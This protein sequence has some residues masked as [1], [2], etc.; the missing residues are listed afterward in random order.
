MAEKADDRNPLL[1]GESTSVNNGGSDTVVSPEPDP[2]P[3]LERLTHGHIKTLCIFICTYWQWEIIQK[4]RSSKDNQEK[5]NQK[6]ELFFSIIKLFFISLIPLILI[7]MGVFAQIFTCFSRQNPYAHWKEDQS[8]LNENNSNISY[9][10]MKCDTGDKNFVSGFIIPDAIIL[11]LS[12]WVY[13]VEPVY[14]LIYKTSLDTL[15]DE[16]KRKICNAEMTRY[17]IYSTFYIL[18][19]CALTIV[20]IFCFGFGR[21]D[22]IIQSALSSNLISSDNSFKISAIICSLS[23]FVALDLLYIHVIMRYTYRCDLL[24]GYL[25]S[26]VK[27]EFPKDQ[28]NTRDTK[29]STAAA[30]SATSKPPASQDQLNTG[31]TNENTVEFT[32]EQRKKIEVASKFLKELNDNSIATGI[33]IVIAGFTA[34]SCIVNLANNTNCPLINKHWQAVVVALRLV[35]WLYIV[36]FPLYRAAEVNETSHEVSV[37]L[38]VHSRDPQMVSKGVKYITSKARLIGMSVQPWLP[39]ALLLT[40]IFAVML[41]SG[42]KYFHLL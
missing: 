13:F 22:F 34:F 26:M 40:I 19:S 10:K 36:L 16:S 42:I 7:S 3:D 20:D 30:G 31:E 11:F 39:N 18:F 37:G 25:K 33:V 15:I 17:K 29:G 32:Y 28:S 38:V 5:N 8:D 6:C 2:E 41:G 9:C 1:E 35:L 4:L 23:G 12:L 27:K 24:I 21:N 14:S